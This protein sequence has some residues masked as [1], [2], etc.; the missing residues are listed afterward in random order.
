MEDPLLTDLSD[1][2]TPTQ[3]PNPN[4]ESVLGTTTTIKKNNYLPLVFIC[5]GAL[6]LLTPLIIAKIKHEN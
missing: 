1:Q 6:F 3:E 2:N 4:T 5:L